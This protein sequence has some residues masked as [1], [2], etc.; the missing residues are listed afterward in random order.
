MAVTPT[1]V[2]LERLQQPLA[3]EIAHDEA[4]A[5]MSAIDA[6]MAFKA[7]EGNVW[8]RMEDLHIPVSEPLFAAHE[9]VID[10]EINR[11]ASDDQK[12][13]W[14]ARK[15]RRMNSQQQIILPLGDAFEAY[16]ELTDE[17]EATEEKP[18]ERFTVFTETLYKMIADSW[19][20]K[21]I[22]GYQPVLCA[23]LYHPGKNCNLTPGHRS[24]R[25]VA[26]EIIDH[27]YAARA[28]FK[29]RSFD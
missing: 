20:G 25:V 8:S 1:N 11:A 26:D 27:V 6:D 23:L 19:H 14:T 16:S 18:N 24:A 5:E 29:G 21:D 9:R 12:R 22:D 2:I 17:H 15:H 10:D 28:E 3:P 13:Y 7:F 4:A